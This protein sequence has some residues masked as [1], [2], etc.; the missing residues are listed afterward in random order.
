VPTVPDTISTGSDRAKARRNLLDALATMLTLD[1]AG[2][3]RPT[4]SGSSTSARTRAPAGSRAC[5]DTSHLPRP[6]PYRKRRRTW[7]DARLA[8]G[9]APE[10]IALRHDESGL[11]DA[12][13]HPAG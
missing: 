10:W 12:S 9:Y 5:D 3:T 13:A 2:S 7:D 11:G 6:S 1:P 8:L 4:G